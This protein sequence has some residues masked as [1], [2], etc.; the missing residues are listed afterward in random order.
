[1]NLWIFHHYATLPHLNG[2]IRPYRFARRLLERGVATTVFVASYQHFSEDNLITD[3]SDYLTDTSSDIPFVFVRTPSSAGTGISRIKNMMAFYRGLFKTCRTYAQENGKPDIIL[4]SS[5]QPFAMVAGIQIAR[6]YGIPC[7][8][9]VRDLWP[10]AIFAGSQIK[11][12]SL[13]GKLLTAGEHW[14]YRNADALVFTKEGDTDYLKE[15]G[16]TTTQGGDIDLSKCHY[17][18]NGVEINEYDRQIAEETLLD[19]DLSNKFFNVIYSGAIRP[20]NNVANIVDTAKLLKAE[21]DVRFLI[22]GDGNQRGALEKRVVAEGLGNVV[23]KGFVEKKYIPFILS[24]S[25]VNL[26]NYSSNKYNWTRG[27]SSNKLFE[28]MASGKPII[29]TIRTGYSIIDRWGCGIELD[30][31][32]PEALAEAILHIR[33][34]PKEEYE[35]ICK[36]A[37]DGAVEFD[38]VKLSEKLLR[39]IN[40]TVGEKETSNV[41]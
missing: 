18:N 38:Y 35:E 41:R 12:S 30:E 10:E 21:S 14:I 19:S 23:F 39:V 29:S 28:Y 5:P 17:I 34:M 31:D 40:V 32:T 8:C 33:D 20:V 24:R 25:S 27:S 26:L 11:A 7:I 2:H 6:R 36:N 16:W 37:R 13:F 3:E 1:M 15:Q 4:A 22:Y 9:E